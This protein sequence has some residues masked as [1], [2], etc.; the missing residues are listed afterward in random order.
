MKTR[1][2]SKIKKYQARHIM[3]AMNVLLKNGDN[4]NDEEI[5]GSVDVIR[6]NHSKL[7]DKKNADS[8]YISILDNNNNL[9]MTCLYLD[10]EAK[11]GDVHNS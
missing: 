1:I 6:F 9:M 2:K 11:D 8:T 3:H 7:G 5:I 4:L 10:E